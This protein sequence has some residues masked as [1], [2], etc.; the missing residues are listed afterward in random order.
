MNMNQSMARPNHIF[1]ELAELDQAVQQLA[2][3]CRLDL[4][5]ELAVRRFRDGDFSLKLE[6]NRVFSSCQELRTMLTLQLRLEASSSEDIGI[7]GLNFLW[8]QCSNILKRFAVTDPGQ[9]GVK[10]KL[11]QAI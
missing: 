3:L 7:D 4:N 1:N 6:S 8:N 10:P 5:N 11:S 9:Y 2:Q